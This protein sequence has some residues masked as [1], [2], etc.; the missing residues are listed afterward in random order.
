MSN[1]MFY[2]YQQILYF[3][4]LACWCSNAGIVHRREV[5]EKVYHTFENS[6]YFN[7]FLLVLG[8]MHDAFGY[9]RLLP[10]RW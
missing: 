9:N 7:Y 3:E 5:L 1:N 2:H 10:C 6:T 4:I 8:I